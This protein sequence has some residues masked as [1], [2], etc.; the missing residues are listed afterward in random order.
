MKI[1][2]NDP[3]PC[4]SGRKF[5]K[6]CI[7]RPS[8]K[9]RSDLNTAPREMLQ[10][11]QEM[12]RLHEAQESVRL[13][14]QGYGKPIISFTDHGYRLVAVGNTIHWDKNWL[15]FPDFLLS[16]MKKTLGHEW[17]A[18]EKSKGQHPI[19]RWLEK[20]QRHSD[21]LPTEGKLKS[22]RMM[23]FLACWLHLGYAL[24]LIAHNDAIPKKLLKRLREP[25]TFMPAYYEAIVG[26]A[27]AVT[28]FEIS[29]AETK[30]TSLPT[31]EFRAK[32]KTS[33]TIY[34]VEAKR[35]ERWKAPT[36]NVSNADFQRELESYVRDQVHAGSRKKLRN[37]VYWFELNIPTLNSEVDWRAVTA[38]VEVVLR[39]AEMNMTV[40]GEPIP[41]A[42]VVV[43]N[44]TFLADED[45]E[46][47]PSFGFLQTI[48]IDDY[49]FG[50]LRE[51]EW[52]T[53]RA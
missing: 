28:G 53:I 1:G 16:F 50:A 38:K 36:S 39:D 33:G 20:F 43:T 11:A 21:S 42:F 10:R 5:K 8:L 25:A 37:P 4:G 6:C 44:H 24:Y 18:R 46:G 31:P 52:V 51:S 2:R 26:A 13:Q 3:C 7:D 34:E 35:K 48:K 47:E 45:V 14:Q 9:A 22:G 17:G 49:P 23:G 29:S 40:A 12:M 19:F 27:L 32:S 30:A 41:A 15:V